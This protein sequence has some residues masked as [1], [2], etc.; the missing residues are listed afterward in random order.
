MAD[1]TWRIEGGVFSPDDAYR[2][3]Q[4]DWQ[5][6]RDVAEGERRVKSRGT[7]YLPALSGQVPTDDSY[8][9]YLQRATFYGAFGRAIDGLAGMV[10]RKPV[11]VRLPENMDWLAVDMDGMGTSAHR[12]AQRLVREALTV[13]RV[14]VLVDHTS[15]AVDAEAN[16]G[17]PVLVRYTTEQILHVGYEFIGGVYEL[18]QVRLYET[19]DIAGV[20]EWSSETVEQVR[21][22]ELVDGIYWQ[23]IFRRLPGQAGEEIEVIQPM[24]AG[25]PMNSIP[26]YMVGMSGDMGEIAKP[27]LLDLAVM[28]V[29]HYRTM[30]DLENGAHMTGLP[31]AVISGMESGDLTIGAEQVWYLPAPDAKAYYMA[32]GGEGL[33]ALETRAAS[34][35]QMMAYLGARMLQ[36]EKRAVETAETARIYRQGEVSV[37]GAIAT[38]VS[39][40]LT[41]A[42]IMATSWAMAGNEVGSDEIGIELNLDF[43]P[44]PVDAALLAQMRETWIAGGISYESFWRAMQQGEV[45]TMLRDAEEERQMIVEEGG[46]SDASEAEQDGGRGD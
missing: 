25:E 43:L 9:R 45:V 35:E 39:D 38:E 40:L 1:L 21:V 14:G 28:N 6:C 8:Q 11:Q 13:G 34:K 23:R 5:L 3:R 32:Y 31:Q 12:Y 36:P 16:G 17:R 4:P 22:L 19:Y 26:F 7:K 30:A 44:R 10:F 20:D 29:S 37:L 24:L 41:E 2:E 18:A 42:V 15:S 46:V 33:A 27:P